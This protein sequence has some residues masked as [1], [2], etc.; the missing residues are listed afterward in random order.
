MPAATR[1]I[2]GKS[3]SAFADAFA[4]EHFVCADPELVEAHQGDHAGRFEI[5]QLL[6]IRPDLVDMGRVGRTA[7]DPLGRFAQ[8]P[9]AGEASAALGMEILEAQIQAIGDA[10]RRFHLKAAENDFIPMDRDGS[11]L[12]LDRSRSGELAHNEYIKSERCACFPHT[13]SQ[14]RRPIRRRQLG[15]CLVRF[16]HATR[17]SSRCVN[18]CD[19]IA[20]RILWKFDERGSV[21]LRGNIARTDAI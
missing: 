3:R 21:P 10:V 19:F 12:G 11:G 18:R 2:S 5:S 14:P 4:I 13:T 6:A 7:S 9:D 1:T 8:N 16:G 17:S 20:P 15:R